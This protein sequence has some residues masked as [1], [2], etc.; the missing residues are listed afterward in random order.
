MLVERGVLRLQRSTYVPSVGLLGCDGAMP[1]DIEQCEL[2]GTEIDSM[3]Y[4]HNPGLTEFGS[5]ASAAIFHS[6]RSLDRT[7][8]AAHGQ[9]VLCKP[10]KGYSQRTLRSCLT[11]CAAT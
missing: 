8:I 7:H 11:A 6:T 10:S 4:P 2:V 9:D 3:P 1:V 5:A